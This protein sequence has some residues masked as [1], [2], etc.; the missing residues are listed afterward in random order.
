[1][2]RMR[3]RSIDVCLQEFTAEARYL[4]RLAEIWAE[5]PAG[6]RDVWYWQWCRQIETLDDL[7]DAFAGGGMTDQQR[8]SYRSLVRELSQVRPV[9]LRLGLPLPPAGLD[10]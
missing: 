1:M 2:M 4:P 7:R 10:E 5:E 3:A 9:L 6:N 8:A